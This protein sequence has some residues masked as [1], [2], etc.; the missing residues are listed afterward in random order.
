MYGS[1]FEDN[2]Q[3]L[4]YDLRQIN[5]EIIGEILKAVAVARKEKNYRDWY[6]LLDDLHTEIDMKFN[7]KDNDDYEDQVKE[8]IESLKKNAG[9]YLGNSGNAQQINN[10]KYALKELN[11]FLKR[12]MEKYKMF[13]AKEEMEM[14]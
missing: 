6:D 2:N 4:A 3:E 1:N 13:G 10:V 7:D 11:M 14:L 12:K 9:A 5:A 8:T